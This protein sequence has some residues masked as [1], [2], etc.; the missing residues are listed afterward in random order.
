[1][2]YKVLRVPP[3]FAKEGK[4]ET[5]E[6]RKFNIKIYGEDI[7]I[8]KIRIGIA[9][10]GNIGKGVEKVIAQNPDMELVAVF[11]RREPE[12]L[13]INTPGVTV[14]NIDEAVNM[15]DKI[16][17]MVLCG[18]TAKDL[19]EQGPKF[20]ALFNTVDTFDTHAKIPEY[21]ESV[22]KAAK[23]KTAIIST[24][25]D[26]GLFSMMR[27][28]YEAVLPDG[29]NYVF[30]GRG[31]SQGHSDAIATVE[32]VKKSSEK[33]YAVQYTVPYE[34]AINEVRSGSNPQLTARQ[35][36]LRECY[37]VAEDGADLVRIENEIK[38][39]P[40]F[41]ADY[42]T[43]VNF[44]TEEELIKNHSKMPHGGFVLR[45]GK[46][47]ENKQIMEFS[48]KLDS[49]PEFTASVLLA[50]ARA[51][52]R[53]SQEGNFGAKTVLDIPLTYLSPKDRDTLIKELL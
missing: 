44:I 36:M 14:Y 21:L 39:M 19:P 32:G 18:G 25:W 26:P 22:N 33:K 20:V 47:G 45:S 10:Y 40:N 37:V 49:N 13:L 7:K 1:V 42:N 41:F 8:M 30:Y 51:A 29:V 11:T 9:G 48:L 31:V 5:G 4:G 35:K 12:K 17:V 6:R 52:Y 38:N 3:S 2:I 23:N 34:D 15:T 46:T 53:M 24:G 16:D 28:V 50:Y 27:M 43:V